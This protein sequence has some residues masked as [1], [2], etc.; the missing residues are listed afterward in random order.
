MGDL[1]I[2]QCIPNL[3]LKLISF[4]PQQLHPV[5]KSLTVSRPALGLPQRTEAKKNVSEEFY[6]L[7]RKAV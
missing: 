6:V 2:A 7:G 1:S 4:I 3:G 5:R